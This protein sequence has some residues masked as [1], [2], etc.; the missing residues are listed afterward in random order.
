VFN[1]DVAAAQQVQPETPPADTTAAL[2]LSHPWLVA[3]KE[4]LSKPTD[5]ADVQGD[6][7]YSYDT[8]ETTETLP[9]SAASDTVNGGPVVLDPPPAVTAVGTAEEL[10]KALKESALDVVITKHLDLRGVYLDWVSFA[11]T[12]KA[13]TRS[14]R[15]RC[16]MFRSCCNE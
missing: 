5:T 10:V 1:L 15:V 12:V 7:D 14:I 2:S 3:L 9:E 11:L 6:D 4:T 8:G 13:N 16:H